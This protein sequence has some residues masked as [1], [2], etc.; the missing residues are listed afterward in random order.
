MKWIEAPEELKEMLDKKMDEYDCEKR[1]MFGY[2]AY[3]VNNNMI[4]G[5]FEDG[6]VLRLGV[7]EKTRVMKKHS[8]IKPFQSRGREM[9]EYVSLPMEAYSDEVLLDEL[10]KKAYDFTA[11]LPPKKKKEKK[12]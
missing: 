10:V 6:V 3:F 12:K 4:G 2:P 5:A 9:K 11:S 7:E 8:S 1:K